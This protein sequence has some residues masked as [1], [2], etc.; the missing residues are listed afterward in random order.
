MKLAR[1]ALSDPDR[2]LE[3]EASMDDR[4]SELLAEA[5]DACYSTVEAVK[6]LLAV[7]KRQAKI[8]AQKPRSRSGVDGYRAEM[9][10]Y[11]RISHRLVM[12]EPLENA[13]ER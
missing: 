11:Y 10:E 4:V 1:R 8:S 5:N 12:F 7:A 2:L 13:F 9:R 3:L 6:A